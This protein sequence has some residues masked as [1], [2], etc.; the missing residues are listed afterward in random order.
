[1]LSSYSIV[2]VLFTEE[3]LTSIIVHVHYYCCYT[4]VGSP[5]ITYYSNPIIT[6]EGNKVI[7]VCNATNDGDAID[8]VQISWYN[9]TKLIKPDGK[10][11]TIYHNYDAII[12]QIYSVLVLDSANN[13]DDGE[14]ICRAF[15]NPLCYSENKINLTV[16][17][18]FIDCH[19]YILWWLHI[20]LYVRTFT[21]Q[22]GLITYRIR[23]TISA[24]KT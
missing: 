19:N 24:T 23:S 8:P 22:N 6:F 17:C 13:T 20:I 7:L 5:N 9:G 21:F 16:E 14:Y 2:H 18:E 4:C 1:M 12:D 10:Y 15:N 11:V 3:Y